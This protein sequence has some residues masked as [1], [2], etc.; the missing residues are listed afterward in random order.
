MSVSSTSADFFES[1]YAEREDPWEFASSQYERDRYAAIVRALGN[2]RYRRAFEPGCSIG[3]LTAQLATFCDRV[4]AMD[5][6]PTAVTRAR[7]HCKRLTNVQILCGS[8]LDMI[9]EGEIDLVVF[10]EIGY[11][12]TEIQLSSVA[13]GL[14]KQMSPEGTLLAVHW[15]GSSR[16]HVLDGDRVH[17]VL[18]TLPNLSL[19]Q[20][21]RCPGFRLDR[22][23]VK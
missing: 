17:T 20:A 8:L 15:L 21:G 7:L 10:S 9:P 1:M 12:F 11:Y 22:W 13:T 3:I 16:D 18:K 4:E 6:S 2:R 19:V 14:V 23:T 5:I